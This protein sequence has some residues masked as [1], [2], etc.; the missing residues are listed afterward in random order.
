MLEPPEI[1]DLDGDIEHEIVAGERL[2]GLAY[3]YY[4]EP[5][6]WWVIALR[7]DMDLPDVEA[8]PGKMVTVPD[9]SWVHSNIVRR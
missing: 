8:V 9:P 4:N 7:N 5:L 1:P 2:E 6:L 3:R